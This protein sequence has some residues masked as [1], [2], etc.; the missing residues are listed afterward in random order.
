MD[1]AYVKSQFGDPVRLATPGDGAARR[2]ASGE[3]ADPEEPCL[4]GSPARNG[5]A[6]SLAPGEWTGLYSWSDERN[7]LST[8]LWMRISFLVA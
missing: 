7:D 1:L 2:I 8:T 3:E 4:E 5:R 6:P